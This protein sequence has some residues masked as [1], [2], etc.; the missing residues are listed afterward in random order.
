MTVSLIAAVSENLVIGRDNG[1]PWRLPAD[2]EYFRKTTIGHHVIMGRKN[3]E[4][5]PLK[6]RPLKGRTNIIVTKNRDFTA[7]GCRVVNSV[8]DGIELARVAG[9]SEVFIIG[10]GEIYRYVLDKNLIDRMY[11]TRIK[12]TF[13]GDTFF[14]VIDVNKWKEISRRENKQDEKNRYDYVFCVYEAIGTGGH[15]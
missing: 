10:G 8:E 14:P 7:D 5:I 1:L 9:E 4:T 12:E 6:F 13:E 15:L 11:I 3:Y 2:M